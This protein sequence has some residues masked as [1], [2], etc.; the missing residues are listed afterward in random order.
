MSEPIQPIYF[1]NYVMYLNLYIAVTIV[2]VITAAL[3]ENSNMYA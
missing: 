3:A 1:A 2:L